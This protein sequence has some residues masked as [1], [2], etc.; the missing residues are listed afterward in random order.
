MMHVRRGP[1]SGL[2]ALAVHTTHQSKRREL[3]FMQCLLDWGNCLSPLID[4]PIG[5]EGVL[6]SQ[7][8]RADLC[9]ISG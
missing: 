8:L 9:L 4:C 5:Q 2:H 6:E 7:I 1:R 3:F